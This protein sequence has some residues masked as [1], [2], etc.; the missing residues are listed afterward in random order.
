MLSDCCNIIAIYKNQSRSQQQQQLLYISPYGK[1]K[2]KSLSSSSHLLRKEELFV[3][4]EQLNPLRKDTFF[5]AGISTDQKNLSNKKKIHHQEVR[6]R[7]TSV[8]LVAFIL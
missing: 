2:E 3:M 5:E 6:W 8:L 7:G 4:T 1:K